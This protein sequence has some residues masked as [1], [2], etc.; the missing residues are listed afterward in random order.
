MIRPITDGP[1]EQP[2]DTD[3]AGERPDDRYLPARMIN[4]AAYCPRLFYLMHVEGQFEHN[5]DTAEGIDVHQRVDRKS[6]RLRSPTNEL[7][8]GS[9]ESTPGDRQ[10]AKSKSPAHPMLDFGDS[11]SADELLPG[12]DEPTS[13]PA[14]EAPVAI[15]QPD[16]RV[17]ARSV[18]LASDRLR[19]VAKLDLIEA[20][21]LRATP[22]DY[23]KG[24]PRYAADGSLSAWDPERIQICLQ[25]LVLREHADRKSVV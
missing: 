20:K 22:V 14:A 12:A 5:R 7:G 17:H 23:K 8:G 1:D 21:G 4:E 15:S 16:E 9:S 3:R 6:D 11:T 18:T 24:S 25:A 13:P 10:T 19:V 2:Q